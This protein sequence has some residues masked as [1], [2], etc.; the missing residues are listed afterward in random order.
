MTGANSFQIKERGDRENLLVAIVGELDLATIPTLRSFVEDRLATPPETLV[1]DLSELSFMD[2]SGLRMLIELD[3]RSR[4][5]GWG[6]SLI[7][8]LHH[9][10]NTVLR[11]TGAAEA[12]PFIEA[13]GS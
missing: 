5:E 10:A 4:A 1:L 2:S 13:P 6:F 8:S 9:S 7:A 11:M 12:L 3:Q